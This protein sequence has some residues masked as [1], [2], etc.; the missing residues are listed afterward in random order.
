MS[1]RPEILVRAVEVASEGQGVV[2]EDIELGDVENAALLVSVAPNEE[3]LVSRAQGI[4]FEL[5]IGIAAVDEHLGVI[6]LKNQ[7]ACFGE[8]CLHVGLFEPQA[9][10]EI[11]VIPQ[12][13]RSRVVETRRPRVKQ[14]QERRP[15]LL[16]YLVDHRPAHARGC[17]PIHP[18]RVIACLVSSY[19][20]ELASWTRNVDGHLRDS[21]S[22]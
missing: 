10:I 11:F 20:V 1:S 2:L 5:R 4:R 6:L 13:R 14:E 16:H 21:G 12:C 7:R 18:P 19:I 15:D 22:P 9:D 3:H 17:L 8:V